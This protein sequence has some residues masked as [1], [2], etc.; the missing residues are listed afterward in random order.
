MASARAYGEALC[1]LG[2]RTD[3]VALDA[4]VGDSTFARLFAAAHPER[5]FEM[6]AAEQQLVAAA[7]GFGVRG[8][9]AF[10][11]TFGAFLTRAFDVIRM[12]AI[13]GVDLRLVG[14]HAGVEGG[15]GGPSQMALEDLAALR[16]V[17]GSTV[18]YP[19]DATATAKLVELMAD[20]TDVA[21]LRISRGAYPVLYPVDET[22]V[23]GGSKV[24]ACHPDD[25][26]ALLGAGVT[27][28]TCL[29][30]ASALADIGVRARVI[31]LYSVKPIDVDTVV[32][33]ARVTGGR[34]VVVEDHYREGGLGAAVLEALTDCRRPPR[35][36]HLAVRGVPG[37]GSSTELL[38]SAGIS[39]GYIARVAA[40]LVAEEVPA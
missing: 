28:H 2:A 36:V 33:A 26:V 3:I 29:E 37:S 22:F 19:A 10:A 5:F 30:A 27:V 31:D 16:A 34:L 17:P 24:H 7:V 32:R 39:A 35:L 1:A 38:E 18:L 4:D 11:S 12:A 20:L 15:E 25:Q 14:C 23:V 40:R 8:Y 9:V 6:F 13:A 21:Y